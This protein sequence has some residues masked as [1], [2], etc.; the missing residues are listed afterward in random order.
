MCPRCHD[1]A[2]GGAHLGVP[3]DAVLGEDAG[4]Q[5]RLHQLHDTLVPDASSHPA[6]KGP[7]VDL[8]EARL[9]VTFEHPLV[10]IGCQHVNL[11]HGVVG[12]PTRAEP[13]GAREEIRLEDGLEDQLD[14]GLHDTVPGGGDGG[15]ILLLLSVRAGLGT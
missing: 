6:Q 10:A 5:E 11:S 2:L 1:A 15:F 3:G 8:V 4:T 9:D 7:V 12:P 13:V 14:A